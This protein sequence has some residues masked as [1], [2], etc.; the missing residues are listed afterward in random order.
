MKCHRKQ[1]GGLIDTA[2]KSK[3]TAILSIMKNHPVLFVGKKNTLTMAKRGKLYYI[4]TIDNLVI[5]GEFRTSD[6][7]VE[8]ESV[9]NYGTYQSVE[10]EG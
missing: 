10:S 3:L 2:L 7:W 5:E 4:G 6:L 9:T 1:K 8:L